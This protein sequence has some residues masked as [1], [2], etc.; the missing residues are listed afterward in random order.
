MSI[1]RLAIDLVAQTQVPQERVN[2]PTRFKFDAPLS[3]IS[4]IPRAILN[5]V[6]N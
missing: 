3:L 5:R 2:R 1:E 6:I 4:P